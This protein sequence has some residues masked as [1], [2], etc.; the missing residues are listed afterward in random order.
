[1][2]EKMRRIEEEIEDRLGGRARLNTT[3]HNRA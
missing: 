1:M 2:E 3:E